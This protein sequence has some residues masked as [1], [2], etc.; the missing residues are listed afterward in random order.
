MKGMAAKD[1]RASV[2]CRH[3]AAH[4][5]MRYLVCLPSTNVSAAGAKGSVKAQA[6]GGE[7]LQALY[8]TLA[9]VAAEADYDPEAVNWATS[10]FK[11]ID[12]ARELLESAMML[13]FIASAAPRFESVQR[14]LQRHFRGVCHVLTPF[15]AVVE[16][17]AVELSARGRLSGRSAAALLTARMREVPK[18]ELPRLRRASPEFWMIRE[19][20]AVDQKGATR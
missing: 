15:R 5:V 17:L 11:G 7:P 18:E 16:A 4:A 13:R 6:P 8:S 10:R 2:A 1:V 3:E 19:G 14:S 12:C 9:G 20:F